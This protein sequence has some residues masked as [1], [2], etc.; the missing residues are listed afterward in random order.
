M[1]YKTIIP[2][3]FRPFRISI[4]TLYL[5]ITIRKALQI[6]MIL[7]DNTFPLKTFGRP[8]LSSRPAICRIEALA[9]IV[10]FKTMITFWINYVLI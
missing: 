6:Y 10:S 7:I 5:Q 9:E 1:G 4:K 2:H 3:K 8:V